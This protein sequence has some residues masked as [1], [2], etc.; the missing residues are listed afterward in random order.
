[1]TAASVSPIR[2]GSPPEAFT[3]DLDT[4]T[5]LDV[6]DL[7]ETL[8]MPL[9]MMLEAVNSDDKPKGRIMAAMVW[10]TKRKDHPG[11][12]LEEAAASTPLSA[13]RIDEERDTPE[14]DAVPKD[15]TITAE[16]PELR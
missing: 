2:P 11:M 10:V 16:L 7:E 6:M 3:F 8:N 12:T 13:F 9:G 5:V 1:M 15:G 14:G 4:L